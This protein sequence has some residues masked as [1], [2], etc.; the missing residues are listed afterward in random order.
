MRN[1]EIVEL[2]LDKGAKVSAVDRVLDLMYLYNRFFSSSKVNI[3]SNKKTINGMLFIFHQERGH[4]PPH[5]H[6]WTQQKTG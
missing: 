5:C 1:I 6:P 4:T 2:L 3:F